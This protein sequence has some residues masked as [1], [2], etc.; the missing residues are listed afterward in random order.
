MSKLLLPKFLFLMLVSG[1]YA[2]NFHSIQVG[3][4][5][6]LPR[7][8][9]KGFSAQVQYNYSLNSTVNFYVYSGYYTWDK[10]NIT[11]IDESPPHGNDKLF[12]SYGSDNHKLIPLYFGTRINFRTIKS[13]TTF[14]D[15]EV[16]YSYFSYTDYGQIREV[17]PETGWVLSY[18]TDQAS[19]KNTVKNLFGV[20][21]GLGVFH[22]I[23][24]SMNVVLSYKLNSN[25]NASEFGLF[26]AFGT[27]STVFFGL[28]INV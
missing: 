8:S 5:L 24:E 9:S 25:F 15:L 6:V 21:I 4:G 16:G 10:Y 3:G 19:A 11:F 7:S 28:G 26:S 27:Y 2:Q 18:N 17:D 22:P 14:I 23:S 1:L 12:H 13:F 20:G